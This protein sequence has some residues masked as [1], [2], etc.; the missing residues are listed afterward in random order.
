MA[1][2]QRS[3]WVRVL[4]GLAFMLAVIVVFFF[5]GYL[6]GLELAVVVAVV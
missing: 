3:M 4:L 1:K 5:I 6:I 2:N